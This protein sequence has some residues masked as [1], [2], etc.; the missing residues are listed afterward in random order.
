LVEDK[1]IKSYLS[2]FEGFDCVKINWMVYTDNDLVINDHRPVLERFT[3]P[4]EYDKCIGYDFP[5][6]YHV[7]SVVRGGINEFDW[8]GNPH[9]PGMN[10]KYSDSVGNQSDG[11]PFQSYFFGKAYIKHFTT[12]T[13]DEYINGKRIRGQAD[14]FYNTFKRMYKTDDF[15]KY[16]KVNNEKLTYINEIHNNK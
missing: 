7:K 10:I 12:K 14:R 13:I 9:T 15:F 3:T 4:M 11:S 5:E 6:N 8:G 2:R 1:D 16:N